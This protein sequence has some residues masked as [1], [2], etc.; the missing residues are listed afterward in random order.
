MKALLIKLSLV[1]FIV[2]AVTTARTQVLPFDHYTIRDGLT[3]NWVTTIFQDARGYLWVGTSEGVSRYDGIGF[4]NYGLA[5]GLPVSHVWCIRESRRSP[6]TILIGTHGGGL[7]KLERG[8]ITSISL[9]KRTE[10]NV[11]TSIL[12]DRQGVIWCGTIGGVYQV[13]GDSVSFVPTGSDSGWAAIVTDL[14][15]GQILIGIET[16]LYKYSPKTKKMHRL[17]LGLDS[18]TFTCVVEDTAGTLWFGTQ[19]GTIYKV[20]EDRVLASKKTECGAL[21]GVIDDTAGQL[22]FVTD[23]GIL[24]V[25]KE[26]FYEGEVV[27]F[28]TEN[29]LPDNDFENCFVDRERNLW[30]A[31]RNHGLCKLA[32]K[33]IYTFPFKE[34]RPDKMNCT[35]GSDKRGHIFV[36]SSQ[37]LWEIWK[38]PGGSWQRYRHHSDRRNLQGPMVGVDIAVDGKLWIAFDGGGLGG[39]KITHNPQNPSTLTLT[40]A[41]SA[42]RD[43]PKG[44]PFG[45]LIDENNQL[46]Y[47]IWRAGLAQIDLNALNLSAYYTAEDGLQGGTVQAILQTSQGDMWVGTFKGGIHIFE[48]TGDT[49]R[50]KRRWTPDDGLAGDRIRSMI[51]RRNGEIW[52]GTRFHGISIYKHGRFETIST[53]DGLLSNAIWSLAEDEQGRVWIGTSVGVQ[54]TSFDNPR[55]FQ[56]HRRLLGQ[57]IGSLGFVTGEQVFRGVSSDE[58]ILYES[59]QMESPTAPPP[60]YITGLRV[61]GVDRE[62]INRSE[63]THDENFCVIKFN[64]LSFKDEKSLRY[65]YRLRGLDETWH[66]P[67][68]Q[69]V[70]VFASL[71]PGVYTFE[72]SAINVDGVESFKPATLTFTILKPIWKR[73]WFITSCVLLVAAI[74]YVLHRVRVRRLLQIERIRSRIATDLHDDIGAGL[75]HIGLLSEVSLRKAG[76]IDLPGKDADSEKVSNPAVIELSRS[77][78]KVGSIARELSA[79][80]SDVVWSIN[81]K[82]DSIE[83]LQHRLSAFA[84]EICKTKEIAL[85]MDVSDGIAKMRLHPEVRRNL[86]LIAKEALHNMAKYSG[87]PSVEVKMGTNSRYITLTVEDRGQGFDVNGAKK[88][89][90][91]TNM[92]ARA[93]KLGGKYEIVSEVGKGT[94]VTAMVPYQR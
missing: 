87:S 39:Y 26:N 20:K 62:L 88:G 59:E 18:T 47:S 3:S 36:A 40:E 70:V 16:A 9:G 66:G 53:K 60:V 56:T 82:H 65:K 43:I 13:R 1:L 94:R 57:H 46:W 22:W 78:E 75:T 4:K 55:Q 83:A 15:D 58:L 74:L 2:A 11:V 37:G 42:E 7:S 29:G 77:M 76:V 85:K 33:N 23:L 61:N 91:L 41:L 71:K 72:V 86:L 79:S 73:W 14:S 92:R 30:F 25:S 51:Q 84:Y 67:T 69:R 93:E 54:Y 34:L 31:S 6:G 12:E 49:Y 52:I 89:N 8:Q 80:M 24:K 38:R 27:H 44:N 10:D 48:R 50:L 64:G 28:T 81:P 45:I 35:A 68:D 5:D 63:F 32:D 21:Q 19:N 90:G 17:N